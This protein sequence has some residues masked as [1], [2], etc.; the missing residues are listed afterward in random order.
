MFAL[1]HAGPG[2]AIIRTSFFKTSLALSEAIISSV[3][4]RMPILLLIGLFIPR[5]II[6]VLWLF[7]SWF[8]VVES[9]VLGI[10][11][12][13]FMPYTLL[14]YSVVMHWNGGE[15]GGLQI[16]VLIF[17]ILADLGI[18]GKGYNDRH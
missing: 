2:R 11:G 10:L 8:S 15:W 16:I 18:P 13:L 1:W 17:A 6:A 9:M 3:I 5:V 4:I 7:S 12:F 14:W